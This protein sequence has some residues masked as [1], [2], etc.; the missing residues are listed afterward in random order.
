MNSK[1]LVPIAA[2]A[3]IVILIMIVSENLS[4]KRPAEST[5]KFFNEKIGSFIVKNA[6]GTV[7]LHKNGDL[8]VVS[9]GAKNTTAVSSPVGAQPDGGSADL[10]TDSANVVI[11]LEKLAGMKKGDKVSANAEKQAIFQVDTVKGTSIEVFNTT[12]NSL[13]MFVIGKTT[14][15]NNGNFVRM[16]GSNDVYAVGGNIGDAFFTDMTRWRNKLILNFDKSLVTSLILVKKDG[17]TISMTKADSGNVWNIVAP[18]KAPAKF[19]QV[20]GI[21]EALSRYSTS[22]FQDTAIADTVS[23]FNK[24]ELSITIGFKAGSKKITFGAKRADNKIYAIVDGREQIYL[25]NDFEV[26]SFNKEIKDL[27][28]TVSTVPAPKVNPA[29]GKK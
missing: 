14:P 27:K 28:D 3:I 20:D 10:P 22:N 2:I 5:L 18:E 8:W 11:A 21:L 23:G 1:K 16:I 4:K 19:D 29:S 12:G 7:T 15:D 25:V 13:G 24:P 17:K 9:R 6:S 26:A